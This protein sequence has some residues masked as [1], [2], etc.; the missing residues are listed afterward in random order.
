MAYI[1]KVYDFICKAEEVISGVFLVLIMIM[2]FAAAVGRSIS[3]PLIWAMD[4]STFLFA[5]VVFFSADVALRKNKHVNVK[6]IVSKLPE[7]IQYYLALFNYSVIVIF[8]LFLVRYGVILAY[9]TRFRTFQGIPG[10]SY[11][12]VTIS[13]PLGGLL[14]LISTTLKIVEIVK[15]EKAKIFHDKLKEEVDMI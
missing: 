5:W 1:K 6:A 11:M 7:R 8:L 14:L 4:M 15:S 13:V 3:H 10:F 2:V 9:S 12:W